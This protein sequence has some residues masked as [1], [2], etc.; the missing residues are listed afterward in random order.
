MAFENVSLETITQSGY[1]LVDAPVVAALGRVNSRAN[2]CTTK[3]KM[4]KL[5]ERAMM[6][7]LTPSPPYL[8]QFE[9]L[10][11]GGI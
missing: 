3:K 2:K 1:E 4:L 6:K 9:S 11:L 10:L 5:K 7:Y 8:G